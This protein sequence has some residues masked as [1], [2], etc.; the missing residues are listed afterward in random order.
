M[1]K[2]IGLVVLTGMTS[3][4]QAAI[5]LPSGWYL[6]GNYGT[7]KS[8][9]KSY[10]TIPKI[11]NTGHGWNVIGGYKFTPFL[12]AEIGY[13]RYTPTLLK[14]NSPA[15]TVARDTHFA[16]DAAA[17]LMLPIANTGLE[18]FGKAGVARINS[19]I[20]IIDPTV[21]Q[22]N[23]YNLNTSGQSAMGWFGGGGAEYY[24]TPN[25]AGNV[26]WQGIKG[27]S[28]TGS[29]QLLS[30]GISFLLDPMV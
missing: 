7:I 5:P 6:E 21:Y 28:K 3:I 8:S 25:I 1:K 24:I 26:Q 13:T 15:E 4:A 12:G 10:P 14:S 18:L 16:V 19:Q 22:A 2:I 20:G 23:N 17:K 9:G 29:L 30:A 27:N 11:K